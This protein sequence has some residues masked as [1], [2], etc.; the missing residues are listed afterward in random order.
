MPASV[1][2]IA[3]CYLLGAIPF[4]LV[5]GLLWR[6]IDIRDLGSG[7]IGAANIYRNL[8]AGPG[9]AVF[10]LDGAKGAAAVLAGA[11]FAQ[12]DWVVVVSG[13]C[14]IAGHMFSPFLLLRGGKGVATSLGVVLALSP[15]VALFCLG[16]WAI[17]LAASRY[18]SLASVAGVGA[19]PV[20]MGVSGADTARLTFGFVLAAGVLCKHVR[21]MRRLAARTEPKIS[22]GRGRESEGAQGEQRARAN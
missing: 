10:C 5:V 16:V 12:S 4:G 15:G 22:F 7:N 1:A 13:F 14:A 20:V 21:N 9:A 8:G 11:H 19:L 6:G 2:I 18:V 3:A 17:V